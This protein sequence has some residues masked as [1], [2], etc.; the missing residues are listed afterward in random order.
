MSVCLFLSLWL[1]SHVLVM[2]WNRTGRH[3]NRIAGVGFGVF[4]ACRFGSGGSPQDIEST[5]LSSGLKHLSNE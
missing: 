2:L 5:D 1:S 4:L 3:S